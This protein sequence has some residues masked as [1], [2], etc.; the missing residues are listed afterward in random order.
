MPISRQIVQSLLGVN[1]DDSYKVH[2]QADAVS[3]VNTR[4]VDFIE[5][6]TGDIQ[7]VLGNT[8]IAN[9]SLES[10]INTCIGALP[11]ERDNKVFFFVHNSIT[12]KHAI[13]VYNGSSF[14]KLVSNSQFSGSNALGFQRSRITASAI[15][16]DF[17]VYS[18][19][20]GE[21]K[22]IDI[23]YWT[24]N[25]PSGLDN[26]YVNLIVRPPLYSPQITETTSGDL[27]VKLSRQFLR[28]HYR[29]VYL[30]G[31][32]SAASPASVL[33]NVHDTEVYNLN[34][35]TVTIPFDQKIHTGVETVQFIGFDGESSTY[36]IAGEKKGSSAFS[37]HNAGTTALSIDYTAKQVYQGVATTDVE[38]VPGL[39]P[40]DV[41]ALAAAKSRVFF[42]N[43]KD[44]LDANTTYS[45][46]LGQTPSITY[47]LS[48]TTTAPAFME[49][50]IFD[51]GV[52]YR[53]A[54][55]R[56]NGVTKLNVTAE[57]PY[58]DSS[59]TDSFLS[60]GQVYEPTPAHELRTTIAD[61][62]SFNLATATS[63]TVPGWAK[64]AEVV[65]SDNRAYS[66][67][68]QFNL[69]SDNAVSL[70][71][72][73]LSNGVK[74]QFGLRYAIKQDDGT[75]KI[76]NSKKY[77]SDTYSTESIQ[78]Y[79]LSLRDAIADGLGWEYAVGDF[80]RV[81][82]WRRNF[83]SYQGNTG[84]FYEEYVEG[85][86]LAEQDGHLIFQI[87]DFPQLGG[88]PD[89]LGYTNSATLIYEDPNNAG[90]FPNNYLCNYGVATIF[91]K[92]NIGDFINYHET[93]LVFDA[94]SLPTVCK[95][96]GDC[97]IT[98]FSYEEPWNTNNQEKDYLCINTNGEYA[99]TV[100]TYKSYFGRTLPFLE[101]STDILNEQKKTAITFSGVY[102]NG[103][104]NNNLNYVDIVNEE[105]L[106]ADL[107][108]VN[109][110]QLASKVEEIGTV[111]LAI[112][113][114]NTASIYIG[115]SQ[116]VA[117]GQNADLVIDRN[118]IGSTN[119][120]KGGYGTS[121]PESVVERNG[122]VYFV[123]SN[124]GAAVRYAQDGLFEISQY[125]YISVF[126]DISRN[127]SSKIQ[128]IGGYDPVN[129]E[130]LVSVLEPYRSVTD[131]WSDYSVSTVYDQTYDFDSG[132]FS[133]FIAASTNEV[134]TVEITPDHDVTGL[135][136]TFNGNTVF[137]AGV[138]VYPSGQTIY[139]RF[140][141]NGSLAELTISGV[142]TDLTSGTDAD[143]TISVSEYNFSSARPTIPCTHA[144]NT[145]FKRW[146][147][148]DTYSAEAFVTITGELYSF[149]EGKLYKHNDHS[150]VRFYGSAQASSFG[151]YLDNQNGIVSLPV[152]HQLQGNSAPSKFRLTS[153][154][155]ATELTSSDYTQLENIFKASFKRDKLTT[156]NMLS[157]KRLRGSKLLSLF[158]MPA[159]FKVERILTDIKDSTGH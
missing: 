41:K 92:P 4:I 50:S 125:K 118:V 16:N 149:K 60:T 36:F 150:S 128:V 23:D 71:S 136:I 42:S 129:E 152:S 61:F 40:Y 155:H 103:T 24:N 8:Y 95:I 140:L 17:L 39:P 124:K 85:E 59:G 27:N 101:Y 66:D 114:D 112:G 22:A 12:S 65:I 20:V 44:G 62:I 55:G 153:E 76:A 1:A 127:K 96:K 46:G 133:T 106:P 84:Q 145:N 19:G 54:Q 121:H 147:G 74:Y 45:Q 72:T 159:S 132:P 111:M 97:S 116:L 113:E 142:G 70:T 31:R 29:F 69:R 47:Q 10:G 28:F 138:D 80:V 63:G 43:Y 58:R 81:V 73:G 117:S 137:D 148:F 156:A 120:L 18:T 37:N 88:T 25:T 122:A 5:G 53:D 26:D 144:F 51:V 104:K 52:I 139:A 33:K 6:D 135:T 107:S 38:L 82:L 108:Q 154:T 68:I 119:V 15:V 13:Y 93:G 123:D 126:K 91:R 48:G 141:G 143:I 109:K 11:F 64:T 3:M 34:E 67:F 102:T 56:T 134:V 98:R 151:Y 79:A 105:Q 146:R 99:R 83:A 14:I 49:G 2:T 131:Y 89:Y 7:N 115:E 35:I 77:L 130:Y 158:T 78:Y 30:D 21:V 90:Q 32:I 100:R 157:G 110:L 94:T 9:S 86:I 57:I 87:Q 75:Y